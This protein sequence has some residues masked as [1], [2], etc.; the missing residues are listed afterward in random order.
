MI[1]HL[2][3]PNATVNALIFLRWVAHVF[4]LRV[5]LNLGRRDAALLSLAPR[6]N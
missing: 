1:V 5:L 3:I 6:G 4:L 2:H